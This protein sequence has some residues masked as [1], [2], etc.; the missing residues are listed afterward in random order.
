MLWVILACVSGIAT[1]TLFFGVGTLTQIAL[2]S[3]TALTTEEV[4][5]SLRKFAVRTTLA[6]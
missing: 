5:L 4:T 3:V 6:D 2:A 1:Q